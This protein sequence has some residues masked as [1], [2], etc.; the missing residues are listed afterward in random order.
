MN[1]RDL[2]E[3]YEEW[4]FDRYRKFMYLTIVLN[5]PLNVLLALKE[6]WIDK[7]S[8]LLG[9]EE[10]LFKN[11]WMLYQSTGNV[12]HYAKTK[13]GG[14]EEVVMSISKEIGFK[15]VYY[16]YD[17]TAMQFLRLANRNFHFVWSNDNSVQPYRW[18]A[19]D[20]IARNVTNS[21]TLV[22]FIKEIINIM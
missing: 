16:R 2:W 4:F 11:E 13:V 7:H 15:F 6:V 12:H 17:Q 22:E 21:F 1:K 19:V 5:V 10:E 18:K 20:G 3:F 14:N 8:L 9:L